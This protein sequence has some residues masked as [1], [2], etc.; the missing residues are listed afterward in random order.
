MARVAIVPN[1]SENRQHLTSNFFLLSTAESKSQ[2]QI[3]FSLNCEVARVFEFS[4]SNPSDMADEV[5][6][7]LKI[8]LDHVFLAVITQSFFQTLLFEI[9][10]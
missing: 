4:H 2:I 5:A 1:R 9:I 6:I 10:W 7:Q 3:C 8:V